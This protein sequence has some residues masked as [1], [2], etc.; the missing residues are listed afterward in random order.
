MEVVRHTDPRAFLASL[1]TG[2]V[3]FEAR[4][5]LLMGLAQTFVDRPGVYGEYRTWEVVD[6]GRTVGAAVITLPRRL[7]VADGVAAGAEAL[8]AAVRDDLGVVPGVIANRPTVDDFVAAW[9]GVTG[10]SAKVTMEQGVYSL[11]EVRPLA[12]AHGSPRPAVDSDADLLVEWIIAFSA[13]ALPE[14]P[15]SAEEARELVGHR[16][17]GDPM[18]TVW[19]WVAGGEVVSMSGHGN[20]TPNGVRIGPVYTPPRHRGNGYATALVAAQSQWLLDR[21]CRFCF[22]FTDLANPT[23]NAIYERIG[24]RKVAEAVDYRFTQPQ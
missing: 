18:H 22:L 3:G 20:V 1:D 9:Q 2:D 5:N 12:A 8:A 11:A 21:G 13:E 19:L 17:V 24:Y 4:N 14:D 15:V 23:S 16:L 6:R 7:V 10:A